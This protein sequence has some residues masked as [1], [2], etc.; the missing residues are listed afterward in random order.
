MRDQIRAYNNNN[1]T[2]DPLSKCTSLNTLL[3]KVRE[4]EEALKSLG[5][6]TLEG[7]RSVAD[8]VE[9]LL[10]RS[11]SDEDVCVRPLVI[12]SSHADHLSMSSRTNLKDVEA[13]LRL[14]FESEQ[15][16]D[17]DVDDD[18][19]CVYSRN[20]Q[21]F[22]N[23]DLDIKLS[24][25]TCLSTLTFS[26]SPSTRR[27]IERRVQAGILIADRHLHDAVICDYSS[28]QRNPAVT[29]LIRRMSPRTKMYFCS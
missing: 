1:Y 12:L 19:P 24:P 16:E 18:E 8:A 22:K 4:D 15:K 23:E 10:S 6:I 27:G 29:W 2:P 21:L 17:K 25:K 20:V 11:E 9:T 7:T 28:L 14:A 5:P 26:P 3:K 13:H